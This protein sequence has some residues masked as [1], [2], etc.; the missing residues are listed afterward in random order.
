MQYQIAN[1][2]CQY[3]KDEVSYPKHLQFFSHLAVARS[4]S[5]AKVR[6]WIDQLKTERYDATPQ[7]NTTREW[8]R[9]RRG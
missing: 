6:V 7:T 3:L 2:L 4:S 5:K 1:D 8:S 9:V